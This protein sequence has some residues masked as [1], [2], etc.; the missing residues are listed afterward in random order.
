MVQPKSNPPPAA[1]PKAKSKAKAKAGPT[2]EKEK[3]QRQRVKKREQ[4]EDDAKFS[5]LIL[6]TPL[7]KSKKRAKS[8]PP[9]EKE[10]NAKNLL[11]AIKSASIPSNK[12]VENFTLGSDPAEK[13]K[14]GNNLPNP[15]LPKN[16]RAR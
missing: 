2:V 15:M 16:L 7:P 6:E 3:P 10:E 11:R 13:R 1:K 14:L 5:E 12:R 8:A 4:I 9:S